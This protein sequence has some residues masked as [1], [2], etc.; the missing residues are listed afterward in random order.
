MRNE[1]MWTRLKGKALRVWIA[2]W[3]VMWAAAGVVIAI[4]EPR[5]VLHLLL[6]SS[7]WIAALLVIAAAQLAVE[8]RRAG[9]GV[10]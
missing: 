4:G 7:P 8:R 9:E 2:F 3:A 6:A 1:N 5:L 10:R